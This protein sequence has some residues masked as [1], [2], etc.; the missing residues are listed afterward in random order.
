MPEVPGILVNGQYYAH[1]NLRLKINGAMGT[2]PFVG[3]K[4][5]NYENAIDVQSVYGTLLQP[6][7]SVDSKYAPKADMTLYLPHFDWLIEQ[8]GDG[9]MAKRFDI[10]LS[11][12]PDGLPFR[13]DYIRG[14]KITKDSNKSGGGDALEV[15]V[16]LHTMWIMRNGLSPIPNLIR[17]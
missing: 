14:A 6:I 12:R 7:G 2:L 5:I 4:E 8:L 1:S 13:Y 15:K 9:Y 3:V 17:G 16:D 10:D 11:Y